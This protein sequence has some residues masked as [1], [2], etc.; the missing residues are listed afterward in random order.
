MLLISFNNFNDSIIYRWL[1]DKK[2]AP[3]KFK[4]SSWFGQGKYTIR[5][6]LFYV[7]SSFIYRTPFLESFSICRLL[8]G[9]IYGKVK[10]AVFFFFLF[11]V[12]KIVIESYNLSWIR[13]AAASLIPLEVLLWTAFGSC[14]AGIYGMVQRGKM[15]P[16]ISLEKFCRHWKWGLW[17]AYLEGFY[18]KLLHYYFEVLSIISKCH[19]S[20]TEFLKGRNSVLFSAKS[21]MFP[22]R[23]KSLLLQ[24]WIVCLS[25]PLFEPKDLSGTETW[26]W[27]GF[28][29][30]RWS[31]G[32]VRLSKERG[33]PTRV[34]K[35]RGRTGKETLEL[36]LQ[37]AL[38]WFLV[39]I[40]LETFPCYFPCF[41]LFP[42]V[43]NE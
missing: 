40:G 10:M 6:Y 1:C 29:L 34:K 17:S 2:K 25:Y 41:C 27:F 14:F 33:I 28:S 7:F 26:L 8:Q 20:S 11:E 36:G 21:K 31:R 15:L 19:L 22:K 37:K 30:V 42:H 5:M 23:E 4:K 13:R 18:E 43:L 24:H 16:Q 3:I 32:P 9:T 38:A 12:E 39:A 35:D